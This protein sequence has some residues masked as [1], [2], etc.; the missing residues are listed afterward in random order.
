MGLFSKGPPSLTATPPK[1]AAVTVGYHRKGP[2]F[3]GTVV[4]SRGK[5]IK[6]QL[7]EAGVGFYIRTPKGWLDQEL[8]KV[9]VAA[10]ETTRTATPNGPRARKKKVAASKQLS[11]KQRGEVTRALAALS[12]HT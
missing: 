8:R 6:L 7:D 3:D 2:W 1:G 9:T 5:V 11:S 12:R 4:E 10:A